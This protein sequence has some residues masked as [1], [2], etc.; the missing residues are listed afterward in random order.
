MKTTLFAI[1]LAALPLAGC[2]ELIG[3]SRYEQRPVRVSGTSYNVYLL[4][5]STNPAFSDPRL[6]P[7]AV[8]AYYAEVGPGATVYCGPRSNLCYD[9]IRR[10]NLGELPSEQRTGM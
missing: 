1:A 6:D 8:F 7:N 5:R 3:A 2:T 9:A 10:F 4:V